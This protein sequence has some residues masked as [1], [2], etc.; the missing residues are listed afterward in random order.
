MFVQIG[1]EGEGLV[2][3]RALVV[4]VRGVGLHVGAQIR[5]VGERF[6][7]VRAPV[8]LLA[9][10]TSQVAL[11]QPRPGEHL[12]ADAATV[13]QLVSEHVHRQG[14]HAHVRLATVDAL[15]RGLRVEATVRLLVPGQIRRRG[16]LFAALGARELGPVRLGG[17]LVGHRRAI[18][19]RVATFRP[20]VRHE[21]RLVRVGH[22][23]AAAAAVEHGENTSDL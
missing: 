12:A 9:G 21:E 3:S 7:A 23:L 14:W 15:L 18:R 2:A 8:R 16:V 10:V 22:R 5:P 4:L 13:G 17:F 11:E 20:A 19:V 6:A 1:L